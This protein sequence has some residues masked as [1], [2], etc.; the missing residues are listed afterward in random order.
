ML[1]VEEVIVVEGKY[2]AIKLSNIVDAPIFV[3]NGFAIFKDDE[4]ME[5]LRQMASKNGVVLLTDSD[6]AGLVIR[7]YL[8]GALPDI[9]IKQAYIPQLV[10]KERRKKQSSKEGFLGVEGMSEK[11]LKEALLHAGVGTTCS[12]K[13]QWMTKSRLFEDGLSGS[14][15]SREL[16]EKFLLLYHLP[17]NLS[18]KRMIE[19]INIVLT[20]EEYLQILERIS[21]NQ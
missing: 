12:N 3:T 9:E 8:S 10:G 19:W 18:T 7:R 20:E 14:E 6:G 21:C 2:D 11:I 5:L 16:R 1:H 15:N 17:K 13:N 4:K